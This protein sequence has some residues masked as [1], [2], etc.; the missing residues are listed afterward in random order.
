M[1]SKQLTKGEMFIWEWQ[2]RT[3]GHFHTYLAKAL[4][5]ADTGNLKRLKKAFP[6]E[7]QAMIN[8]HTKEDWWPGVEDRAE[9]HK[10]LTFK[11]VTI[12]EVK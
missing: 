9:N 5:I 6:D 1:K 7:T 2:Y 10:N 8:F 4:S 12:Q 11:N 3:H